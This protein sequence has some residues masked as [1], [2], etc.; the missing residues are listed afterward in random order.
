MKEKLER[1][2]YLFVRA[3]VRIFVPRS[4]TVWDRPFDGEPSIFVCNHARTSGPV[5]VCA[6]F[7]LCNEISP[8]IIGNMLSA[9][10]LPSYARSDYWWAQGKWYTKLL[11]YTIPY[12]AA[13]VVP[14]VLRGARGIPVYHDQRVMRTFRRSVEAM[15]AGRSIVLFPEK[16]VGYKEYAS[17]LATG[18]FSL[19]RLYHRSTGKRVNFYPTYIDHDNRL[20]HVY[21]PV[22][23]DPAIPQ[24]EQRA[25][26]IQYLTDDIVK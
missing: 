3:V 21:P 2:F 26:I 9:K 6:F 14:P 1:A 18:F 7:D 12:L 17:D 4:R 10:E 16:P 13:L 22:A 20:I 8:W 25:H 24:E 23:Y 19:A 5:T 11:D 15:K